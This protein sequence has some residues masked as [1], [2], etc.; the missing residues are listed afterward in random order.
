ML[1]YNLVIR[2][3]F[4]V[5]LGLYTLMTIDFDR[6]RDKKKREKRFRCYN[7]YKKTGGGK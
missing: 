1:I 5:F 4:L 3:L 7:I 6:K 2:F